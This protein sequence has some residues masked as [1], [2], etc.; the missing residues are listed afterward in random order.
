L[1]AL[2]NESQQICDLARQGAI[3]IGNVAEVG[4]RRRF[5]TESIEKSEQPVLGA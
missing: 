4:F 1:T 3:T 2:A 5:Q